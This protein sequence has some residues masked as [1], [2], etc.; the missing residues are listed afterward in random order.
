MLLLKKYESKK[1]ANT[2]I[3]HVARKKI[4]ECFAINHNEEKIIDKVITL[5]H[6]SSSSNTVHVFTP[7]H[8]IDISLHVQIFSISLLSDSINFFKYI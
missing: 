1:K 3:R 8:I 4:R 6:K 7:V 2:K 5:S